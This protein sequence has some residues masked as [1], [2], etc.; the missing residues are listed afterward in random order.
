[1]A[2]PTAV[3]RQLDAAQAVLEQ[4]SASAPAVD[5]PSEAAI[6]TPATPPEA[7]T[8]PAPAAPAEPDLAEQLRVASTTHCA[9]STTQSCPGSRPEPPNCTT[10]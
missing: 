1:M 9:A 6:A 8:E 10:S 7:R 3:Q 2:I 5:P 4:S